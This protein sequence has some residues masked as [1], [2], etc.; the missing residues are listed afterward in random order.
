MS[1]PVCVNNLGPCMYFYIYN[2]TV[3][4]YYA[5]FIFDLVKNSV[6]FSCSYY[7]PSEY[8]IIDLHILKSAIIV[9]NDIKLSLR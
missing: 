8:V 3:P 4:G 1:K 7:V 9:S 5:Q 6:Y 2:V